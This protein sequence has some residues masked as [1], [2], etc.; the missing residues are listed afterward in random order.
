MTLLGKQSDYYT[1]KEKVQKV[2]GMTS[3]SGNKILGAH[4]IVLK[5]KLQLSFVKIL[6]NYAAITPRT[7]DPSRDLYR[8]IA[9]MKDELIDGYF[10]HRK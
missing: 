7:F 6:P 4:H 1:P 8:E 3:F 9:Y 5:C 10:N 2:E